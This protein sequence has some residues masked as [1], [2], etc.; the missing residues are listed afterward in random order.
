MPVWNC[1]VHYRCESIANPFQRLVTFV[2]MAAVAALLFCSPVDENGMAQETAKKQTVEFKSAPGW[3]WLGEPNDAQQIVLRREF[4]LEGKVEQSFVAAT[5]DNQCDVFINEKKATSSDDWAHLAASDISRLLKPGVNVISITAKNDG[6]PAGVLSAVYIRMEN[7]KTL[8]FVTDATWKGSTNTKGTDWR[9]AGFDDST[10]THVNLLGQ[11][12]DSKLPWSASIDR[13]A[14]RSAFRSGSAGEFTP[15]IA[16]NAQVP[17]GFKIEKIFQV[18]RSMGSWV[19]LTT[20]PQGRLFASDQDGAGIFMITPGDKTRP[21]K[22]EKLPVKLSGAH[23]LLWAFDSLY[24]VVNGAGSGLHRLRDTDGDGLVDSDEFCMP[25]PGAG[26]HGPHAVI[27]SPDKKSLFVIAGNHTKLPNKVAGSR[28][29]QNWNEDHLLPRRWDANGHA[30][31]ILAP[32]GWICNVDPSG[33]EWNVYSMG[34]RNQYDIAFNTDGDLFTYDADME[35]DFGSPWYRPTRVCHATSGS[36]FGWRS[37]TGKWPTYYEDSLPPAVE[38]GP[39]SPTGVLFGTGAKFPANYQ[40]FLFILD[41]TYSTIY[42]VE[43]TPEGSSYTGKKS[44]FVTGSPLPVTD[45]IIGEDGAFYFAVGGRGTQSALYRVSYEG[46]ESTAPVKGTEPRGAEQRALR[47][48]LEA[49][50]G[51]SDGDLKVILANLGDED[52]FIRYA[53]RVALENQP[54]AS[55]RD[56]AFTTKEPKAILNAMMAVAHQGSVKDLSPLVE[57]LSSVNVESLSEA[58]Q[59]FWLRTLEIAFARHGEPSSEW[60]EKLTTRL[61]AGYPAKSYNLNAELV[62]LLVYLRSPTVIAKTL[63]LMDNLGPEPIPDW[64]YLVSRNAGYGGTVGSMLANMPPSRA[65]HFAF[66]LRNVKSGWTMAQRKKYLEFFIEAAKKPGGNSYAKFLM[67]FREDSLASCTQAELIVLEPLA[68]VSLVSAPIKST[69][70]VGPGRKWTTLD[71]LAAISDKPTKR[72][73]Q[74]G[75]NLYHATSCAKCHRI[76]GEGGAIGPDLSTA[77]KKFSAEDMLNAIVEPSKVI[78]DQYGSQQVL[79]SDGT[80]LVGRAVEIG[81]EYYVYTVDVDAKPVVIKKSDV[82]SIVSS[83][84]SQMPLGLIDGLNADELKDLMAYVIA[85]GDKTAKVYKD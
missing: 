30:A 51:K 39:G 67:Q 52:R 28:I 21:T 40:R 50:H 83:K 3:V 10:W 38:I 48:R 7:G 58:D 27:L 69:P 75:Q 56:S 2:R 74:V 82:E 43:L 55:W 42:S 23:G 53:A 46:T 24:A 9:K 32:G 45:A 63:G 20:G 26:E 68:G 66:M 70:P 73:F 34:Y 11:I 47:R 12:G 31:G 62:Q 4:T 65:I 37:G 29:P 85:A 14:L 84:I 33:K 16:S 6:G 64:G 60:R 19:S 72:N 1:I 17:P 44:D 71:A 78:S 41:W 36:E 77:G 57:K 76:G 15:E 22:V 25:L 8:E 79:T 18:P 13:D 81:D 61:D 54:F 59:L 49:F 5:A 35:W 80:V